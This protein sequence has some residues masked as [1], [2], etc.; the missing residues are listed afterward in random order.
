MYSNSYVTLRS[1]DNLD[2]FS[3]NTPYEFTNQLCTTLNYENKT[4]VALSEIH[5]PL[6]F[7]FDDKQLDINQI[8]ILSD[9]VDDSIVGS[10]RLNILKVVTINKGIGALNKYSQAEIFQNL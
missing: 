6:N 2:L 9:L 4:K 8:F 10:T 1:K 7:R 5:F 3:K